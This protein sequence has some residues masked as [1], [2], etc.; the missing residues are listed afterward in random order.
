MPPK[1]TT[2]NTHDYDG[3][4][5]PIT[6]PTPTKSL[7]QTI[8]EIKARITTPHARRCLDQLFTQ[9]DLYDPLNRIDA[10][11]LLRVIWETLPSTLIPVLESVLEEIILKGPC[12]Q[13]RTV[14]LYQLYV[15][16]ISYT[17]EN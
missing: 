3:K 15:S 4:L 13:G 1:R 14:R 2:T 16:Y 11:V 7:A 5:P 8:N 6:L 9:R 12:I 17:R 10:G